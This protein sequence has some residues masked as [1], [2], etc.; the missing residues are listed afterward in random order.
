[1]YITRSLEAFW[2]STSSWHVGINCT[3]NR[4]N[5]LFTEYRNAVKKYDKLDRVN[6]ADSA[7]SILKLVSLALY[8]ILFITFGASPS[9]QTLFVYL[10]IARQTIGN[11]VFEVLVP[12]PFK[13]IAHVRSICKFD[14]NCI[15][16]FVYLHVRH[17]GILFLRS[18]Y[19]YLFKNIAHVRSI[20]KFDPNCI[21]VF[22]YLY[23]CICMSDTR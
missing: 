8:M 6:R 11:I 12:W 23:L 9:T 22:V 3:G 15:C 13:N 21:C 14:P 20:C 10:L 1:M 5:T 2:S 4:R 16:V 7:F 18:S 17:W 19:H